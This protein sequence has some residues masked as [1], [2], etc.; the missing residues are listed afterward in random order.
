MCVQDW[1]GGQPYLLVDLTGEIPGLDY[2]EAKGEGGLP[3]RSRELH[4][5]PAQTEY[6][7][8]WQCLQ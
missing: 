6:S 7:E 3:Q 4:L 1:V 2:Q 8:Q 5:D